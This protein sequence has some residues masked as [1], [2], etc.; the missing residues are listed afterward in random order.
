MEQMRGGSDLTW[1]STGSTV[2]NT[3]K[4]AL[5]QKKPVPNEMTERSRRGEE[6]QS[7][8]SVRIR[9]KQSFLKQCF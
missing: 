2:G 9:E 4:L 6:G 5:V 7:R 1:K 3:Q 8:R